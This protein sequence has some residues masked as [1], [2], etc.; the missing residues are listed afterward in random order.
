MALKRFAFCIRPSGTILRRAKY[1]DSDA[2][3][4]NVTRD[5]Q[6]KCPSRKNRFWP[7]TYHDRRTMPL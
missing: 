3:R 2:N 5:R 6:A 4:T 7:Q 1:T